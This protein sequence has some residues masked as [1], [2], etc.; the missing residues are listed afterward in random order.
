MK[1]R[2]LLLVVILAVVLCGCKSEG[3]KLRDVLRHTVENFKLPSATPI[4]NIV[5]A[6]NEGDGIYINLKLKD[7]YA[8]VV[9]ESEYA[10]IPKFGA[11][12]FLS[13]VVKAMPISENALKESQAWIRY[14]YLTTDGDTAKTMLVENAHL[15]EALNRLNDANGQP[16]YEKDF[17]MWY[18]VDNTKPLLPLDFGN[19]VIY[20]DI[21]VSGDTIVYEY[22]LNGANKDA[23]TSE[24]LA[25]SRK[26]LKQELIET[27]SYTKYIIEDLSKLGVSFKYSY[28][29]EVGKSL[30]DIDF[31]AQ[32][33][34]DG[35][36]ILP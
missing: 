21:L 27:Y 5:D 31:S 7:E 10:V 22:T 9:K 24:M 15:V 19:G 33:I 8:K 18:I 25:T 28:Q 2:D 16:L 17:Y 20:S 13:E 4:G 11:M 23:V 1:L 3:E 26:M 30:F 12:G 35:I 34:A 29:N 14:T 6:G 32:E 36:R